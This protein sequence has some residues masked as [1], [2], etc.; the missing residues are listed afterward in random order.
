MA[1]T[2]RS[3]E[4][5]GFT[6]EWLGQSTVRITTARGFTIYTDPV[7]LDPGPPMAGLIVITHH[8]V[9]HCLPEF[10]SEIK[11]DDTKLAAFHDSYIKHCAEDIKG[12]WVRT[13]KIGQTVELAGVRITG[14]EAYTKRGFHTRGEGCGFVLEVEGQTI[15]FAG[16]TARTGEMDGLGGV[17]VAIL[18]ICDNTYTIDI[19]EMVE[20][21]RALGPGLFIPVHYTPETEPD[22]EPKEGM[23]STKDARFFTRKEDPTRLVKLLEG[24]GIEVAVLEKLTPPKEE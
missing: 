18:P 17:D 12:K 5:N 19:D 8:H 3:V 23:F 4:H 15:Y 14:V 21:A 20:A 1:E 7:F 6:Y 9:D 16:D 11:D 13:V 22:P 24:T 10:V 2:K